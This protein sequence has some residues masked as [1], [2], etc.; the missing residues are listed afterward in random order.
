MTDII[1]KLDEPTISE[2]LRHTEEIA[3]HFYLKVVSHRVVTDPDLTPPRPELTVTL[4]HPATRSY[5]IKHFFHFIDEETVSDLRRACFDR[6]YS[7][8][9]GVLEAKR[10]HATSKARKALGIFDGQEFT[11]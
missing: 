10:Y 5:E 9:C 7:A 11:E 6:L 2:I 8:F 1:V 4:T 3:P